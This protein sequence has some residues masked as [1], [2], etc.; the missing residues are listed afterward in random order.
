MKKSIFISLAMFLLCSGIQA[1]ESETLFN[2]ARVVGGFGGPLFEWGITNDIGHAT[3][4]GGGIIVDNVFIGAYGL[5]SID[6]QDFFETGE[7]ESV[8]L[9]HGGLWLGGSWP[10]HKLVHLYGSAKVGWGA[11]DI[12]IDD[13]NQYYEDIDKVF[14]LS[15]EIGVELN[16][17]KWMRLSGTVGY[18]YLNGVNNGQA[19]TN[20]DFR[21]YTAGVTLR[22][23]WFGNPRQW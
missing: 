11:L 8:K 10:T 2:N 4:G 9:A 7:I 15:P 20:D 23:G 17:T 6:F 21:G 3:G 13:P 19:F 16:L 14:V 18:R 22:F 1:Q 5:G 12:R